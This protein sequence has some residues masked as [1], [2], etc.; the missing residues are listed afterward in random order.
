[1]P[2]DDAVGALVD[3]ASAGPRR[4]SVLALLRAAGRPLTIGEL[5]ERTGL[6]PNTVRFHLAALVEEEHV[7]RTRDAPGGRG[8]PRLLYRARPGVARGPRSYRLL[9]GMLTD[10]ARA[11]GGGGPAAVEAGR[12]WGRRLMDGGPPLDAAA[13]VAR[14]NRLLDDIGFQ[15]TVHGNPTG[16][17]VEVHLHHCPFR[18]V[19]EVGEDVVCA[20]HLGLMQGALDGLQAP[21][22]ATS[23]EPFVRPDLCIAHLRPTSPRGDAHRGTRSC[24]DGAGGQSSAA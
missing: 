6:H 12:T 20:L 17:D 13:A 14:M 7:E 19:A 2:D 8:R 3:T 10:L 9:A 21:V 24:A 11:L 16:A 15:P 1:V 4:D 22:A 5:A 23:L 18:E